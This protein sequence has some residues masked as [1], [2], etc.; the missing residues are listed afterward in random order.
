MSFSHMGASL[1]LKSIFFFKGENGRVFRGGQHG[2]G[3]VSFPVGRVETHEGS[4]MPMNPLPASRQTKS[5][6]VFKHCADIN[7]SASPVGRRGV[8]KGLEYR[9][10]EGILI[11]LER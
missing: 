4:R 8:R 3:A 10:M 1:P 6:V 2:G 9:N 5:S 11:T 7:H